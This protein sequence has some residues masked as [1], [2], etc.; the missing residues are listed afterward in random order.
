MGRALLFFVA[1]A[2]SL[3]GCGGSDGQGGATF[4]ALDHDFAGFQSWYSAT[5]PFNE[6]SATVDPVGTH[7]GFVSRRPAAGAT[8]YPIGT[9]IVKAIE[10][11]ADDTTWELFGMAKRG[12]GFNAGGA[13]DWEYFLLR[14]AA[15][16]NP[17]HHLARP[18]AVRRRLRH[19]RRLLRA[20]RRRR[21]MQPVPRRCRLRGER[22]RHQPAARAFCN[23]SVTHTILIAGARRRR[24]T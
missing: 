5:L 16:G 13:V 18:G 9:I 14:V 21:R 4:I 15:D 24:A 23:S 17:V 7:V 12:G 3:S 1:A 19:G 20:R 8:R 2:A 11:S 6:L 10:P 22:P